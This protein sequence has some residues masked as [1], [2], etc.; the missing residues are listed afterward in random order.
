MKF[1]VRL[2]VAIIAAGLVPSL[3]FGGPKGLGGM[4]A[5]ILA[6]GLSLYAWWSA[7]QL[8]GRVA[9]E[10]AEQESQKGS[11]RFGTAYVIILFLVKAPIFVGLGY[12]AHRVGGATMPC[13]IAGIGLVYFSLIGWGASTAHS[14]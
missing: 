8:L 14:A 6:G 13:F 11:N 5:G 10:S 3:I 9:A 4:A 2:A 12:L 7:I 1:S